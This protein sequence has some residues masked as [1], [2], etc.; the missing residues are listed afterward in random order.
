MRDMLDSWALKIQVTSG[1]QEQV[2]PP[3]PHSPFVP[4][5]AG[6]Y[7]REKRQNIPFSE[8]CHCSIYYLESPKTPQGLPK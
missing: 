1:T 4:A 5:T 8:E 2:V 7:S 3:N 6:E